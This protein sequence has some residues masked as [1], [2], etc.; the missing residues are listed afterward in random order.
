[1]YK[2]FLNYSFS[3]VFLLQNFSCQTVLAHELKSMLPSYDSGASIETPS[4]KENKAFLFASVSKSERLEHPSTGVSKSMSSTHLATG[5]SQSARSSHLAAGVS[6]SVRSTRLATGVSEPIRSTHLR[7]SVSKSMRSST[8]LSVSFAKY[9]PAHMPEYASRPVPLLAE[10]II[11][12]KRNRTLLTEILPN[13]AYVWTYS[14]PSTP[15]YQTSLKENTPISGRPI[16]CG[17]CCALQPGEYGGH[18]G[19]E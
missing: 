7:A 19:K 14:P 17:H 3:I 5:V 11:K 8:G 1:M 6:K 4:G 15:P 12:A 9:E 10:L 16:R 18:V 13:N 2:L